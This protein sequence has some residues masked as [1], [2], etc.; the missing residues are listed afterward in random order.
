MADRAIAGLGLAH[1]VLSRPATRRFTLLA[2]QLLF[3]AIARLFIFLLKERTLPVERFF[4]LTKCLMKLRKIRDGT[5]N[6]M[7]FA[8]FLFFVNR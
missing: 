5:A 7:G 1:T 8:N 2:G 4:P 6:C 3:G